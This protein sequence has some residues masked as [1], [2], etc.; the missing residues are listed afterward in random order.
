MHTK[1]QKKAHSIILQLEKAVEKEDILYALHTFLY[2]IW[3]FY[4]NVEV[5]FL[6]N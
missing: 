1:D 6:Y 4:K 5:Y 3:L 2:I